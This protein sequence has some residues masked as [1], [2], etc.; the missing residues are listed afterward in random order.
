M[1]KITQEEKDAMQTLTRYPEWH[2]FKKLLDIYINESLKL[3]TIKPQD[4]NQSIEAQFWGLKYSRD[5]IMDLF[6][7]INILEKPTQKPKKDP[8]E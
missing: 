8:S 3:T 1:I 2:A 7:T 5:M 6:K 4:S